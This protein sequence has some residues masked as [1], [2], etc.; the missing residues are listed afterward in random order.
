M[1]G[2]VAEIKTL[3]E[4]HSAIESCSKAC[5]FFWAAWHEPSKPG[6]QMD[7]VFSQLAELHRGAVNCVKVEAEAAPEVSAKLEIATVPTFVL[8]KGGAA[9]GRIEGADPPTLAK[10]VQEL[11]NEHVAQQKSKG[12]G[13]EGMQPELKA[14]LKSI[15]GT[16]PVMLFM[17]GNAEEPKCKFSRKMAE[18]LRGAKVDFG[19]FDILTDEQVRAGLKVYSNWP[20]FPQLYVKGVLVG[21]VDEVSK[22]AEDGDLKN[23]LANAAGVKPSKNTAGAVGGGKSVEERCKDIMRRAETMVF[24]K[25]TPD[26]PRCGFS[27]TL[28]GLLREENIAFE[29]FDILEDQEV[30][31]VLKDLSNWP[32]YPQLYVQ[33]ELVGGLDIV[34]EMKLEG[35]LAPQLGVTPKENLESRLK[36]LMTSSPIMLFMKGNPDSPQCGFSRTAVGLLREEGVEFGTFDILAD[37]EVRQGLKKLSEWPTYPQ[38]YCGGEL[39]GGLDIMKEMK[40]AGELEAAL[41]PQA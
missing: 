33:G 2:A 38:L 23:S 19:S 1:G 7:Q 34:K 30:R 12:D 16:S 37:D 36:R 5:V 28:V 17:K 32:T 26:A 3:A 21:G 24:M 31:E 20:T 22:L 29:S 25:G 6:G 9:C 35:P 14:K 8:V 11:A 18:M 40:Q 41:R 15:I 27:R 4:Y 10:R 13:V 39:V